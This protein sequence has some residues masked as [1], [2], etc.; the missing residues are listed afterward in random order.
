MW[1][2]L[3]EPDELKTWQPEKEKS[4]VDP[5]TGQPVQPQPDV[6]QQRWMD[7]VARIT[8]EDGGE[9]MSMIDMDVKIIAGSTQPTNRM[10]KA[11]VAME[12]VKAQIYDPEAALEYLDDPKKDEIVER[13]ERKRKEQLDAI[14]QGEAAK[15]TGA[16]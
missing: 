5:Q 13:M 3:I 15:G 7:A 8:G 11:G 1:M 6:I 9:P 4:E 2:R 14:R 12:M 10:A 16:A